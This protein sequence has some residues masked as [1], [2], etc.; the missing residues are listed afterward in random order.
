M[1]N[2][3][4]LAC[5]KNESAILV[6]WVEHYLKEGVEHIHLIDN[7]STDNYIEKLQPYIDKNIVTLYIR[8]TPYIQTLHLNE[9]YNLIKDDYKWLVMVDLD[10]FMFAPGYKNLNLFLEDKK[11]Y[12]GIYANWTNFGSYDEY[13]Q[14]E[15]VINSFLWRWVDYAG[16]TK[17]I[18]QC[19]LTKEVHLHRH[20]HIEST[21]ILEDN[22]IL[23]VFHYQIQSREYFDTV[24]ATRGDA[25]DMHSNGIRN[26]YY[27]KSRDRREVFDPLLKNRRNE[28]S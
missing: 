5:F 3:G 16:E 15:S 17:G 28:N 18:I 19:S 24:K 20:V 8:P 14:P 2:L 11:Q 6:E 4:V 26:D 1:K 7:S 12:A 21:S 23:K 27:F 9:I 25:I 22:N 13:K 10:E